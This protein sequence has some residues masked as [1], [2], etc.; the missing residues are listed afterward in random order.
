M[1]GSW[2]QTD[3]V[4]KYLIPA[5][6]YRE[7]LQW[8]AYAEEADL[9]NVALFGFTAKAWR[10]ANPNLAKKSNVRNYATI[11]ELTVLSNL[12]THNA[13]MIREGKSK[14]QRFEIL[15]EIAEYQMRICCAFSPFRFC[16]V[17]HSRMGNDIMDN[18]VNIN[19]LPMMRFCFPRAMTGCLSKR[20]IKRKDGM[21]RGD[22]QKVTG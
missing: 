4:K 16:T 18:M 9:L 13:T 8:I 22:V 6:N 21:H 12:E 20:S 11:N 17:Y 7:D 5:G 15:K 3:A 1:T 19:F 2:I 14:V 10:E